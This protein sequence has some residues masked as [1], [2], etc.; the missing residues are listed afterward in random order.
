MQHSRIRPRLVAD[1]PKRREMLSR[2]LGARVLR[3]SGKP[4]PRRETGHDSLALAAPVTT[5][6]SAGPGPVEGFGCCPECQA[7]SP[8]SLDGWGSGCL[9]HAGAMPLHRPDE[10]SGKPRHLVRA[11]FQ[12]KPTRFHRGLLPIQWPPPCGTGSLVEP[13]WN[14]NHMTKLI[15]PHS[16]V[17]DDGA[18]PR[19]VE[20]TATRRRL[21]TRS[22]CW[23]R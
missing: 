15:A 21:P 11:E 9:A 10:V 12:C 4:S 2:S 18:R 19:R 14:R 23:P 6:P 20:A 3:A 13:R 8:A 7:S 1:L 22:Y 5:S 17:A 16:P